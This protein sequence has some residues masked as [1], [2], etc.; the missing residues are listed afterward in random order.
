MSRE[1]D[2]KTEDQETDATQ[3]AEKPVSLHPLKFEEAVRDLLR[4]SSSKKGEGHGR[5]KSGGN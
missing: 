4:V 5:R 1:K 3:P 2:H